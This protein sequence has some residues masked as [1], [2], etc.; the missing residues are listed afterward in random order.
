LKEMTDDFCR[1][2]LL[3]GLYEAPDVKESDGTTRDD[4]VI[5]R[6][7]VWKAFA[8]AGREEIAATNGLTIEENEELFHTPVIDRAVELVLIGLSRLKP[9]L[10]GHN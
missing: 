10:A 9:T 1:A 6:G 3:Q 7:A 4:R 8:G 5:D 2:T